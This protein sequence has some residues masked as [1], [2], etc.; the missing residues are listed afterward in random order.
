MFQFRQEL[1][2]ELSEYA[3][4]R[5]RVASMQSAYICVSRG[6]AMRE[7]CARNNRCER[8]E[9]WNFRRFRRVCLQAWRSR[10]C[11]RY[12]TATNEGRTTRDQF[13]V[14]K[15]DAR[16]F[17]QRANTRVF[18]LPGNHLRNHCSRFIHF[19][20]LRKFLNL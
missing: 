13:P 15:S 12:T 14:S 1:Q 8:H 11:N 5:M 9:T 7:T 6:K 4:K 3:R 2:F 10:L 17:M 16:P 18:F 19:T 20:I